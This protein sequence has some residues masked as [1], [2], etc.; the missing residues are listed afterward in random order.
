MKEIRI[1]FGK[2]QTAVFGGSYADI[3]TLHVEDSEVERLIDS[4]TTRRS[5]WISIR[6][7]NGTKYINTVNILWF[8]IYN[9]K[10]DGDK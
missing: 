5:D 7:P 4:I 1:Y 10:N 8:D 3:I 2:E 6:I 9:I